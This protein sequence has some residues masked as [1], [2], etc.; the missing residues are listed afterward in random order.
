VKR[1]NAP[2]LFCVWLVC[3]A[4]CD[5][6]SA[7]PK[8]TVERI[9]L[10]QFED[11]P[12]LEPSYQFLP[13]ETAY[14][15]CRLTGY[16][17]KLLDD[18]RESA[19][20]AW[21]MEV[22]DPMGVLLEEP[23]QGRI[24]AELFPEDTNWLPKFLKS[25]MVPPFAISGEYRISVRVRDEIADG[26]VSAE[27]KFRVKGHAPDASMD[28]NGKLTA[29]NVVFLS[30]ENDTLGT[31]STVAHPGG[32]VWARMDVSGYKFGSKNRFSIAFG[33]ALENAEGRQLFSQPDAGS[34]TDES[35]YPQRYSIGTL[36]LNLDKNV[37]AGAYTLVVTVRDQIGDQ[38][39]EV[40][41]PFEVQ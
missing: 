9:A 13:G 27:L 40:R 39:Y 24:D 15:S 12:L 18:D 4:V 11:G 33:M 34:Q 21:R 41:A 28:P 7:A 3:G 2:A 1:A 5:V 19:K 16:Q 6:V 25:F 22:R 35:F 10:H 32:I 37:P 14:F 8:L 23:A 20:L 36:T 31:R 38:N 26:E 17:T 29:G 30:G